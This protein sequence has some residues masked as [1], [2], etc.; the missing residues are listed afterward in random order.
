[1]NIPANISFLRQDQASGGD[2]LQNW[3][4]V[5]RV[6]I[7]GNDAECLEASR[8]M[9]ESLGYA[10]STSPDAL[11]A[12]RLIAADSS[13]GIILVDIQMQALDGVFLL[14]EISERFMA[15]RPLVTIAVGEDLA[16]DL[17]VQSMRAGA[18]DFL[19]KPVTVNCLSISLRHAA[20]R[21]TRLAQQFR[22]AAIHPQGLELAADAAVQSAVPAEPSFSDLHDLG[23]KIIKSRQSRG[24]FIDPGLL[25]EAAWGIL[26]DLAVAG[27]RGERVATSSACAAAQVPLST[28]LRHV[29]QLIG[30]G[31]IRRVGDPKDKRRTFLELQPRAFDMM[32]GYLRASWEI[33]RAKPARQGPFDKSR[34]AA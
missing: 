29:N 14:N 30:A 17:T 6:L 32:N 19:V 1:M 10:C 15:L 18:S 25:N 11:S 7:V 3:A 2:A 5:S 31:L 12:L 4:A 13:I 20:S 28:A 24:K 16:A 33:H 22:V 21:W 34:Y 23:V 26:L 27:L 9:L 8:D